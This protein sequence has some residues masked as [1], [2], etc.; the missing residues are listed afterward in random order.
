MITNNKSRVSEWAVW[1]GSAWERTFAVSEAK[2]ISNVIW[3]M[4]QRGKFI[5][6]S[7]YEARQ[8]VNH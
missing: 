7:E 3:R 2:A 5:V 1:T 4:R 8:V 6:K